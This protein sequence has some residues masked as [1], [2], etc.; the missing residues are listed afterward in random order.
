MSRWTVGAVRIT[1]VPQMT[2]HLPLHGLVPEATADACARVAP[3]LVDDGLADVSLHGL[4]IEAG[5]RRILVDTCAGHDDA[6]ERILGVVRD[7]GSITDHHADVRAAVGAAGWA[8]E[9]ID[10]VVCTHLHFDHVGGNLTDDEPPSRR[11]ATSWSA[12]S[13]LSG[14]RT[15][16]DRQYASVD[17]ERPAARRR[18]SGRPGRHRSPT[19]RRPWRSCPRSVTPRATSACSSSPAGEQAVITGDVAHHP[20]ELLAPEWKMV[21]DDDPAQASTTRKAFVD[22]FGDGE[23][24]ILG[25]HFGGSSAGYLDASTATWTRA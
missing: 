6:A 7:F 12:T 1:K 19:D 18:R 22:R 3:G 8:P 17:G 16:S 11:P 14:R 5:D 2:W 21:A 23:T 24:L 13:G 10:T 4:V 9:D 15:R 20:V 25:T